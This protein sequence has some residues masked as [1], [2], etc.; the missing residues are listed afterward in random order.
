MFIAFNGKNPIFQRAG[1]EA[2]NNQKQLYS[3]EP[4]NLNTLRCSKFLTATASNEIS[5]WGATSR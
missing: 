5:F 3:N 2:D 1:R 4:E